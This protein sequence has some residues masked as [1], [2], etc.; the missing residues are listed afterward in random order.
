MGAFFMRQIDEFKAAR[1]LMLDEQIKA[2][3]IKDAR[4]LEAMM[5]V[6]RH[7]F[8]RPEDQA[9]SYADH[10][11]TI[12]HGQTISQPYIVAAMSELCALTGDE[13]VL[14]IGTGC[15]YQ[16]AVLA[17][18]AKE[19]YSLELIADLHQRAKRLLAFLNVTNVHCVSGNGFRGLRQ[20]APFD[21]ILV[22][23]APETVPSALIEQLAEGGRLVIPVGLAPV[24]MLKVLQ[25]KQG[26]IQEKDILQVSF[27]P[28]K[29]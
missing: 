26:K 15:G 2:R 11:L 17:Q 22:T 14:E 5:A 7:L 9:L 19:V 8:V 18:L 25:K 24:Q 4:V 12:G 20:Q 10:P 6:L 28:M 13:K 29:T 16:S 23:C 21:A 3:G 27:V 1:R